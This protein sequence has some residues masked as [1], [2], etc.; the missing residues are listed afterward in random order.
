M[1]IFHDFIKIYKIRLRL[2][3]GIIIFIIIIIYSIR[4]TYIDNINIILQTRQNKLCQYL[5]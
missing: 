2:F 3:K 5:L 1:S 4:F